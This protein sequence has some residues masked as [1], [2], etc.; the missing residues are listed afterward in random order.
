MSAKL[1]GPLLD[2]RLHLLIVA[3]GTMWSATG[4]PAPMPSDDGA[5]PLLAAPATPG[6]PAYDPSTFSGGRETDARGVDGR[7]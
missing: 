5:D 4:D 7:R 2:V 6:P 3:L 1:F